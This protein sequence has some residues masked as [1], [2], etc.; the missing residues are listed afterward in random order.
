MTNTLPLYCQICIS[1][2]TSIHLQTRHSPLY[3]C[4]R[5]LFFPLSDFFLNKSTFQISLERRGLTGQSALGLHRRHE[6]V[7]L[8]SQHQKQLHLCLPHMQLLVTLS[9]PSGPSSSYRA[10]FLGCQRAL[11]SFGCAWREDAQDLGCS[12]IL[13]TLA[14]LAPWGVGGWRVSYISIPL[15]PCSLSFS[16]PAWKTRWRRESTACCY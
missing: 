9:K 7:A 8:C 10:A 2:T 4:F 3:R 13:S 12:C 11:L 5:G 16:G 14:S 1:V 6:Y 15:P